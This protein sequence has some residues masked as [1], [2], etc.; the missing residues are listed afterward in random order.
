VFGTGGEFYKQVIPSGINVFRLDSSYI[1]A[2]HLTASHH[3]YPDPNFSEEPENLRSGPA[4]AG[5]SL[6]A[7]PKR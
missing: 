3:P 6:P 4:G 1:H 2:R 7:S 5:K